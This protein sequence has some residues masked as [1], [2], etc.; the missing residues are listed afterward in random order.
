MTKPIA[1]PEAFTRAHALEDDMPGLPERAPDL[2]DTPEYKAWLM[3][4]NN[5]NALERESDVVRALDEAGVPPLVPISRGVQSA[6]PADRVRW[7][8][9]R[10]NGEGR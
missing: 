1:P 8:A 2:L 9:S 10:A 4:Y 5:A 3:S 7:L 6:F